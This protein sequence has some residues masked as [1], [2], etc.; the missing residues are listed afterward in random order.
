MKREPNAGD[1]TL[2]RDQRGAILLGAIFM[3]TFLVGCLWYVM[4]VGDAIVY[5]EKM[6][7]GADSVAYAAAVYHARGMNIIAMLNLIMAAVLAVLVWLK[8]VQL[9]L[10]ALIAILTALCYFTGWACAGATL[11][12]QAEK[13]V[14]QAIDTVE[15]IVDK[16]LKALSKLQGWIG[17]ATPFIASGRSALAANHYKPTV[18]FGM[19]VSSAMVPSD[20]KLGLPVEEDEFSVLCGK[21]GEIAA[22]IS[23]LGGVAAFG[24][25]GTDLIAGMVGGLVSSFPGYFCGGEGGGDFAATANEMFEKIC[26]K[27]KEDADAADPDNDFD[28]DKC[29]EDSKKELDKQGGTGPTMGSDEKTP[30]KVAEGS[31]NGDGSFQVWSFV[32]G[33]DKFKRPDKGVEIADWNG[34]KVS[35]GAL[36]ALAEYGFAQAE[37]YYDQVEP[38]AL[39]WEDYQEDAMWNLRWRARLRRV[40]LPN[41]GMLG[42]LLGSG[43]PDW[44]PGLPAGVG[45]AGTDIAG[46]LLGQLGENVLNDL[47]EDSGLA[48]G[49]VGEFI[50]AAGAAKIIH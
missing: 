22:M 3:A 38:D 45:E 27:Q 43:L 42:N 40:R 19:S 41:A 2:L 33:W 9:L 44:I 5:R 14:S 50:G 13:V 24:I 17:K 23:P 36:G 29:I 32:K 37:F 47:Y 10:Y 30:K 25:P 39:A 8:L 34:S 18:E 49:P 26:K 46:G 6:Q 35:D 11:A 28:V 1:A 12:T 4:G 16:T 7:D 31:Q 20:G 21:A 48:S 15:P